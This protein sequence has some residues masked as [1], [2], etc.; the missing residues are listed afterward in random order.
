M[1]LAG[2]RDLVD[3]CGQT[4][5]VKTQQRRRVVRGRLQLMLKVLGG[6]KTRSQ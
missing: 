5:H 6:V 1:E 3:L 2:A 4:F